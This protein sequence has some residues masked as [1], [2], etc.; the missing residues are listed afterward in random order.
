M[1]KTCEAWARVFCRE[2]TGYPFWNFRHGDDALTVVVK[3]AYIVDVNSNR[4][5]GSNL[6]LLYSSQ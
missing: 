2:N 6:A 5:H 3:C 1:W 4:F